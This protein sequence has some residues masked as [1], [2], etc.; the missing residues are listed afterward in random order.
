MA[1]TVAAPE[2]SGGEESV[3]VCVCG[4]NGEG[5]G[6]RWKGETRVATK[7]VFTSFHFLSGGEGGRGGWDSLLLQ[8]S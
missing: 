6:E 1:G 8:Y 7:K 2:G 4:E 3:S 5:G